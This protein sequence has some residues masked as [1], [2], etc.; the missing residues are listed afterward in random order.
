MGTRSVTRF[1]EVYKDEKGN[2]KQHVLC[3]IYQQWD[4][5]LSGVGKEIA[6]FLEP[7][8]MVNGLSYE[9]DKQIANGI[10]CLAAQFIAHIK[11]KAGSVYM[12]SVEDSQAYNYDIIVGWEGEGFMSKPSQPIVKVNSSRDE[13]FEGTVPELQ[14]FIVESDD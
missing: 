1:I 8:E 11:E 2:T 13:L 10:G 14:K 6:D 3:A 12:T 7:I 5:Y 4:G 9:D